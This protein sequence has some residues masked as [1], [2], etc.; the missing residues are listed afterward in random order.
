MAGYKVISADS[1]AE[2]PGEIFD[3]LPRDYWE[4]RPKYESIDGTTWLVVDGQAILHVEP[5]NAVKEEDWRKGHRRE[6]DNII[7][8]GN[9]GTDIPK[10]L[11]D[12]NKDGVSAEVIYPNGMFNVFSSPDPGFQMSMAQL[13]NNYY[14]DAFGDHS[15]TFVPSAV[16]PTIDIQAAIGEV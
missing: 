7:K 16:V 8:A 12:L 15:D 2:E 9:F 11:S 13:Y 6:G 5:T 1:H 3:G 14:L 4:Q 10:R